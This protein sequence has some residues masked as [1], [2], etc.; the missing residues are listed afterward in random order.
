MRALK[1][2]DKQLVY[3]CDPAVWG[4]WPHD[5]ASIS[6]WWLGLKDIAHEQA[7]L[8]LEHSPDD[9]RLKN[10]LKLIEEAMGEIEKE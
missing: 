5:L 2:K 3:T 10:N 8:A 7:K 6:A 1:I 4:H 9:Q